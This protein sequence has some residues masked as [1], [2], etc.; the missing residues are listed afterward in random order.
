[1]EK[2]MGFDTI[3]LIAEP[4]LATIRLN[5]PERM[6]AVIEAMYL[7]IQEALAAVRGD[8][9]LR[10][11]IVTGSVLRRDGVEKQ[12]FCAGADLKAH[13]SGARN[14]QQRREYV[15]LAHETLRLIYE[16]PM[17][18]IAAVNGPARGA[19]AELAL[20][21]DFLLMAED[22]TLAFPEI[23]LG[24]FVGGGVTYLL[25]RQ[26]GLGRA[27]ELVYTGRVLNGPAAVELGLA[28]ACFPLSRLLEES[29]RLA[30]GL[31][32]K[33][34]ISIAMAKRHLQRAPDLDYVTALHRE[35]E[36]VLTCMNTSDW[37]EGLRAFAE[38]RKPR[39]TGK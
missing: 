37:R 34:P 36:A 26:I 25:P 35:A 11:V 8:P 38:K 5:R 3:E 33:A 18:V 30:R 10:G 15:L 19:G 32:D 4:P 13:A 31:A 7:E 17:P 22:A 16:F 24:T 27:K 39:F 28:L 14:P 12:A 9:Q 6:N 29:R 20:A 1:M 23:G 21:C 2:T